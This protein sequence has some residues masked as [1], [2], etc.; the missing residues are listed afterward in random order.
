MYE[1][2]TGRLPFAGASPAETV[3]NIF[4]KDP[5]PIRKL[6]PDRSS[7]LDRMVMRLLAKAPDGRYQ[8]ARE[9]QEALSGPA[10]KGI[11]GKFLRS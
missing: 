7:H 3:T 1:M 8:T 10:S 4:D 2:A 11:R 6:C 9:L 5:T